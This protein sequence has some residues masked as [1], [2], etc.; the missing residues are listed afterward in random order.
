MMSP[1]AKARR[2]KAMSAPG[3]QSAHDQ[4]EVGKRPAE[5][6]GSNEAIVNEG[7]KIEMTATES[8]EVLWV[9][10]CKFAANLHRRD[11]LTDFQDDLR[12]GRC[13]DVEAPQLMDAA[14]E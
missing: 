1:M 3:T 10:Y 6:D 8:R 14:I 13:P 4:L 9:G 2:A 12:N 7:A 5:A 11:E